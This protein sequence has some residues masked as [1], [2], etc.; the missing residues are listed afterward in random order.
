MIRSLILVMVLAAVV[1]SI[2]YLNSTSV[3]VLPAKNGDVKSLAVPVPSGVPQETPSSSVSPAETASVQPLAMR[4]AEKQ[5]KFETGK[6]IVSPSGFIN[7]DKFALKDLVGKK[8]ILIDFWTYSCINCIRT[9]PYLNA[10]Y[11]KYKD[12]GLEIVGIHSPEFEFEKK[13]ENVV[14]A[15]KKFGIKYPVV[16]DN[17]YGTWSAYKNRYWPREYLID[18]DGFIVHDHIGEG[19]YEETESEIQKALAERAAILGQNEKI[20]KGV[21]NPTGTIAVNPGAPLSPE[22]YFGAARNEY[23]GNGIRGTTGA[24]TLTEPGATKLNTLYLTGNW[25]FA[26]EYAEN[27]SAAAKI[28]FS[29]EA[30]NVYLVAGASAPVKIK[31]LKDGKPLGDKDIGEDVVLKNGESIVTVQA[32]RLYKLIRGADWGKHTIELIIES[33]GIRAFTFTF[34]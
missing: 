9:F 21:V 28:I 18:I 7:A 1:G 24:Q 13:Y 30:K 12:R 15:V 16:L 3:S 27:K 20:A 6:E 32:E 25:N 4:I 22:T 14:A 5:K 29:Y 11:E 26:D 19:S 17:D 23:L 8:V 31:I 10:W 33:P 2:Y 34:G